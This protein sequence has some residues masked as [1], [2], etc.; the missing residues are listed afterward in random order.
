MGNRYYFTDE[1]M[2]VTLEG[3]IVRA[4]SGSLESGQVKYI[5]EKSGFGE[6]MLS[7]QMAGSGQRVVCY[8]QRSELFHDKAPIKE[9]RKVT[10]SGEACGAAISV[11][12]H[13]QLDGGRLTQ[14]V[15]VRNVSKESL[16]LL[17]FGI[18]LACHTDFAWGVPAGKSVIGH[19]FVAGCGSHSTFYRCD[20]EGDILLMMPMEGTELLYY[21]TE[22]E[23]VGDEQ[24]KKGVTWLYSLNA[25]VSREAVLAGSKLRIPPKKLELVP[26]AC[27]TFTCC[28]Q[29]SRDYEACRQLLIQ[30]GQPVAESI[31]GYTV[32][33]ELPVTLCLRTID[34]QVRIESN[35]EQTEIVCIKKEQ[36]RLFYKIRFGQLGEH[37]LKVHYG[38]N[39]YVDLYY[40]VTEPI[41]IMLQKRGAFIASRQHRNPEKWYNGLFAEC[42][43]ETGVML[44]PDNYD[45]IGGWRIYEVTCDD[46]GLSKPAFLSSKLV[47]YP[48]QKEVDALEYYVEHFVWGGLQRTEDES[49]PYG[50]YGIPDWHT[51]RNSDKK[52]TDGVLHIWRI[53]DYPHI[54]LMY[55]NL[56]RIASER[57]E[58]QTVLPAKTYLLRAY[59]TAI[60]MFQIP[61][62]LESWSAYKTGL[63]NELIIPDLVHALLENGLE[64]EAERLDRHWMKKAYYFVMECDDIFGSEYPFDTTGFE[65]TYVLAES[66]IRHAV[67]EQKKNP[68]SG[69]ISYGRAMEL[70][71]KQHR[72]NIACRGV[73][74]PAYFWYGSDYR[75]DN[76]HYML[77]YM[78][79]MGG[80]SL[81]QYA[82]YHARQPFDLLRLAYGSML[83]S[84]ALMNTGDAESG[85]GYW[86]H[87]PEQDGC[88]GGGFEP[89]YQ[90][91]TWLN[92]PHIGGSWYYSC[93]IDLGFCAGI[94]GAASIL[95]KDPVFGLASYGCL[96]ER[97]KKGI[98]VGLRDGVRKEFHYLAEDGL[99]IHICFQIGQMDAENGIFLDHQQH[100]ILI[101]TDAKSIPCQKKLTVQIEQCGDWRAVESGVW[102]QAGNK[103]ELSMEA[104]EQTL[105]LRTLSAEAHRK[106]M[107]DLYEEGIS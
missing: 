6:L 3:G 103:T 84:Y 29:L 55:Y 23:G 83:S 27:Y 92:Q 75:G 57:S 97:T 37:C 47:E 50:I 22:D 64:E 80:Y 106:G 49:F 56:Y 71:E 88:A 58:V 43:N 100:R 91:E 87:G 62:E 40:F 12:L 45:K 10:W 46:P 79:Q 72:C 76:M 24:K 8:P 85:Y 102:I 63:Y 16:M 4:I 65:S 2:Q 95:A 96:W 107:V 86:F 51:L 28:Y 33:R 20:G 14:Q 25:G 77:S 93:E 73:L 94:R 81:L 32:P 21:Q 31:P 39:E 89:Q 60:A 1:G 42:N 66:A 61:E 105:S 104:G 101:R 15:H 13:Y 18:C 74:E 17:D 54:F 9:G 98:T 69:K 7:Y 36:N 70:L 35:R 67:M 11:S 68:F 30:N 90:G 38:R 19:H 78:A 34:Q 59:Q 52:G 82:L 99:R 44:G 5:N 53:Y 26:E 48:V 41:E